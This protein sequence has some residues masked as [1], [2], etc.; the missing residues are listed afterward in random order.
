MVR[1]TC[2]PAG[3][4]QGVRVEAWM[5]L[6]ACLGALRKKETSDYEREHLPWHLTSLADTRP[7][8]QSD[9]MPQKKSTMQMH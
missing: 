7:P 5:L 9:N 6:A 3:E 8:S 2:N 4:I 1:S